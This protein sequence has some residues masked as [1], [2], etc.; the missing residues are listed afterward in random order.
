[1]AHER[2]GQ[3]GTAVRAGE[4]VF[5]GGQSGFTPEGGFTGPGDPAA[6]AEQAMRNIATLLAAAGGGMGH[7]RRLTTYMTDRAWQERVDAVIERHLGSGGPARV[8]LIVAG[9][10]TPE[11]L[12]QI[13]ADAVIPR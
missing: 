10:A 3:V 6:Q 1:M 2:F 13:D 4:R 9:L 11:M 12:V 8:G 7:I 5:I